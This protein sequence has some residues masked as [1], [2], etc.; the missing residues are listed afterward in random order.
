MPA[1]KIEFTV[2]NG[3]KVEAL[4]KALGTSDPKQ[5]L[6]RALA[7]LDMLLEHQE[8]GGSITLT[9][10]D[11]TKEL[12]PPLQVSPSPSLPVSESPPLP[13]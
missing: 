5:M 12:M 10:A 9:N 6:V 11:G 2:D 4:M 1:V 8:G 13:P 7:T 3:A